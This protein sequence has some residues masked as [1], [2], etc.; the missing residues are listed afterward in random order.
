RAVVRPGL[1]RGLGWRWGATGPAE[2]ST[3]EKCRSTR[4]ILP[5]IHPKPCGIPE[6]ESARCQ[7]ARWPIPAVR[8]GDQ[9]AELQEGQDP[10][11]SRD[12]KLR[13]GD[14]LVRRGPARKQCLR[15]RS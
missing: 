15:N 13:R 14:E 12:R 9:A 2:N 7:R 3:G 8:S 10:E 6:E 4:A 1:K 5:R 11:H